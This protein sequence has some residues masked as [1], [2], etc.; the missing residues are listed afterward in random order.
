MHW[1]CWPDCAAVM[2]RRRFM[3]LSLLELFLSC[4]WCPAG[5]LQWSDTVGRATGMALKNW[6]L[7]CWWWH[8]DWSF[9]RLVAPF[10]STTSITLS[11]NKIQNGDIIEPANPGPPGKW[12]LN[13][14]ETEF[15]PRAGYGTQHLLGSGLKGQTC[16][17]S[18][19]DVLK[20]D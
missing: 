2:S 14:G 6:V 5:S 15:V 17:I 16:S 8:F 20:D 12:L 4:S 10:V 11:S 18:W 1:G 7:V 13:I 3:S 9:A 19:P